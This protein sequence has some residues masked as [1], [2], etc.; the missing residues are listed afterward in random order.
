MSYNHLCFHRGM[1]M[2]HHRNMNIQNHI[3]VQMVQDHQHLSSQNICIRYLPAHKQRVW[4][5][6]K[7]LLYIG[8]I[9]S[10]DIMIDNVL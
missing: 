3:L 6:D 4:L 8:F 5:Y 9:D 2:H 7:N 1:M 10:Y